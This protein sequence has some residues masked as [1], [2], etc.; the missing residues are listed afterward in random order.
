M[1][2]ETRAC[3]WCGKVWQENQMTISML[4]PFRDEIENHPPSTPTTVW[5][6]RW[7]FLVRFLK[8]PHPEWKEW[9]RVVGKFADIR[10]SWD[11]K[12]RFDSYHVVA[13]VHI[14]PR[15]Q[16]K[17]TYGVRGKT[18]EI[19]LWRFVAY[20]DRRGFDIDWFYPPIHAVFRSGERYIID[21]DD[22]HQII[23][24][25]PKETS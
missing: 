3:N 24:P 7:V 11:D 19:P 23:T 12:F 21:V 14:P 10:G 1:T 15:K 22:G 4:C 9:D 8:S 13:R 16:W 18:G 20:A 2:K 25:Q 5:S 17:A 6:A